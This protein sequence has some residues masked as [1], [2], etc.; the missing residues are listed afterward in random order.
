M[1]ACRGA[2]GPADEP[3][4]VLDVRCPKGA[5]L[6]QHRPEHA[7]NAGSGP[8]AARCSSEMPVVRNSSKPPRSSG[9][10]SAA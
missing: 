1:S 6:L 4:V 3:G 10:P 5:R 9:M 7:V 8:I 2:L